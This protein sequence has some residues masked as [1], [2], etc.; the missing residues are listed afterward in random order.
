MTD[1]ANA[2]T[3]I[4]PASEK[5]RETVHDILRII[6]NSGK[7]DSGAVV[8]NKIKEISSP[9]SCVTLPFDKKS[10]VAEWVVTPGADSSGRSLTGNKRG[11]R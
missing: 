11:Q 9:V 4:H 10:I 8:L 2:Y 6:R 5:D 1:S 3:H 7:Q